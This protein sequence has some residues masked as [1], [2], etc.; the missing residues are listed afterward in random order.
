MVA[1]HTPWQSVAFCGG[2]NRGQ[3]AL[4]WVFAADYALKSLQKAAD[5][6]REGVN[7]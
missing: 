5:C 1:V 2:F 7:N 3:I 6:Q 4:K